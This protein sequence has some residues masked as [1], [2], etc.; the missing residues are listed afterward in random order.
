[1][2][3]LC[4]LYFH[5]GE[6]TGTF[7]YHYSFNCRWCHGGDIHVEDYIYTAANE[8]DVEGEGPSREIGHSGDLVDSSSISEAMETSDDVA[9]GGDDPTRVAHEH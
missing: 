6:W 8:S 2:P 5:R 9:E 4:T 3:A 1:V 7:L